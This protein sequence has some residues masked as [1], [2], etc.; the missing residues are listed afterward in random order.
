[1]QTGNI[2]LA[3]AVTIYSHKIKNRKKSKDLVELDGLKK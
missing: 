2:K 1:M 3:A